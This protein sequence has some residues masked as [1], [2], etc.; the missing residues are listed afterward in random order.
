M[1]FCVVGGESVVVCL[2][3]LVS[4]ESDCWF[5]CRERESDSGS[6]REVL[7]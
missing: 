7:G 1:V 2:R 3:R 6:G 4:T 5:M